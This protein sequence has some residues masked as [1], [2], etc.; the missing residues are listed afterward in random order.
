M[1]AEGGASAESQPPL[2]AAAA[3]AAAA[4]GAAAAGAAAAPAAAA[5]LPAAQ[6]RRQVDDRIELTETGR[7]ALAFQK[8]HNTKG[9]D[10]NF[11]RRSVLWRMDFVC[12][13]GWNCERGYSG[14]KLRLKCK[15]TNL[16]PALLCAVGS[17]CLHHLILINCAGLFGIPAG[18]ATTEQ[19]ELGLIE[20]KISGQHRRDGSSPYLRRLTG[21]ISAEQRLAFAL[22]LHDRCGETS[23]VQ[24]FTHKLLD[25]FRESVLERL[26]TREDEMAKCL[27][28]TGDITRPNVWEMFL[29]R[30]PA[31]RVEKQFSSFNGAVFDTFC[32]TCWGPLADSFSVQC[33]R[34]A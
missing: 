5:A 14:C 34:Q 6:R 20:I 18:S 2:A 4:S 16:L 31:T 26:P 1:Q 19:V 10:Q 12:A 3:A 17:L 23:P 30:P 32:L 29:G 13:G 7:Q 22:G 9:K 11:W 24:V 33:A 21:V 15:H 27:V 8:R 28:H 25:V